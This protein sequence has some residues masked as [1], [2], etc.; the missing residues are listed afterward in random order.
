MPLQAPATFESVSS[1]LLVAE[2]LLNLIDVHDKHELSIERETRLVNNVSYITVVRRD[3]C[4]K[5]V[6]KL[7]SEPTYR[8]RLFGAF[9]GLAETPRSDV[10]H[11]T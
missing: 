6:G 3:E 1:S 8:T 9:S 5:W 10:C 2:H 11:G 7:G 4:C